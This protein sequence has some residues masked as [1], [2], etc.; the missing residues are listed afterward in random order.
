MLQR[1]PSYIYETSNR[2][3][4][5]TRVCQR[6]YSMGITAPMK[7]LRGAIQGKDDLIFV[8]F[9]RFPRFARWFFKRHWRQAIDRETF[10]RHFRPRYNPWEQ[11]IPVA[12]GL[13]NQLRNGQIVIKTG[14]IE[15]F[16]ETAIVMAN[17]EEIPCDVCILATGF[18]LNLLKFDLYVAEEKVDVAGI[19]FFKGFML[20][21]VPNYFHPF[22]AWHTAWTQRS[23]TV[24]KLAIKI[25]THMK[26][27]SLHTVSID[28]EDVEFTPPFTS[29]YIKRCRS[30]M[31]RFHG[32]YDLPTIDNLVSY[33]FKPTSFNFSKPLRLVVATLAL[34]GLL[35]GCGKHYWQAPERGY[36]DFRIDSRECIEEAKIKYDV[37]SERIYR[38]CMRARGWERVQTQYPTD[39]Q[40]RGPESEKQLANP[41]SPLGKRGPVIVDP[42]CTRRPIERP[43]YCPR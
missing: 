28:R 18:N 7:L 35:T 25:M 6:L 19:N 13:K 41:P 5:V 37:G 15:R 29:S 3:G 36:V 33:R 23:E 14:E 8:G 32:T 30:M 31:P 16:T 12:V 39:R 9:R 11:R 42:A 38:A 22:G 27:H 26:A 10:D 34:G 20:G 43:A 4:P 1:S 21:G 24:T 17:G 40:F 2:V